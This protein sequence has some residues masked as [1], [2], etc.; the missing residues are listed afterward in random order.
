[1]SLLKRVSIPFAGVALG[2][3]AL[4][5]L[6]QSYSEVLRGICGVLSLVFIVLLVGKLVVDAAG[7]RKALD[8]PIQASV[9]GTF[10]MALMLLST[11][12]APLV[13]GFA[14]AL[15]VC[16]VALHLVLIVWFSLKFLRKLELKTVFASY[17][18]VYVG[19]V[20]ASVTAPAFGMEAFGNIAFWFGLVCLVAL[21][22]LVTVRYVRLP[23][24]PEPAR[25]VFCI[26][27]APTSLCVAGYVQSGQ[28]KSLPFALA[29]LAIATI[30]YVISLVR[31]IPLLGAKF[32]PS[33]ASFTFPFVISAIASKQVMAM[34]AKMGA[35][36]PWLGPV[37]L[38]ETVIAV[39]L[40][41]YVYVRFC[42]SLARKE[43]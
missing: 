19:I 8:N 41:V 27:A 43:A 17:Y 11:Y 24:V 25:P 22:V 18:I 37:V 21:L 28:P 7:V 16:A 31:A 40:C 32:F 20:V 6:L 29:L 26:Y 12:I 33:W 2:F 42:A 34:A 36:L 35:P 13:H 15:W 1:M 9:A 3:A 10:P 38:V 23:E 4:G 39:V 30:I 14:L 5:N